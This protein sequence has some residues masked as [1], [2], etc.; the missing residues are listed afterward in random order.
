V[1]NE[2]S[3][4]VTQAHSSATLVPVLAPP[5]ALDPLSV[6]QD[7]ML[8]RP[9]CHRLLPVTVTS[10]RTTPFR[11]SSQAVKQPKPAD[12]DSAPTLATQYESAIWTE[13]GVKHAGGVGSANW[14]PR[15]AWPYSHSKQTAFESFVAGWFWSV[16]SLSDFSH[17]TSSSGCKKERHGTIHTC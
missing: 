3:N 14:L 16:M 4:P 17:R 1:G 10:A 15:P 8:G 6:G 7:V 9:P 11:R 5:H 12:R 13:D 2:R